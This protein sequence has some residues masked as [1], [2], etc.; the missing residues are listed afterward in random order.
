MTANGAYEGWRR[1]A[2]K[3]AGIDKTEKLK[4]A[5]EASMRDVMKTVQ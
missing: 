1:T 2:V 4:M 3:K 5:I